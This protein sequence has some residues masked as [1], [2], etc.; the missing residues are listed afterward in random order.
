MLAATMT[1]LANPNNVFCTLS[2]IPLRIKN[3]KAAP[4]M[5]PAKGNNIPVIVAVFIVMLL[6]LN[7]LLR[8]LERSIFFAK[9][10]FI[11]QS[12]NSQK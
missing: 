6:I 5:V 1:P 2:G 10:D 8:L 12:N 3:T 4:N 11:V 9:L 7:C